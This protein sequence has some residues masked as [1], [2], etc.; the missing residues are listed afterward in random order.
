[1]YVEDTKRP[2]DGMPVMNS[3]FLHA[4][5]LIKLG[6]KSTASGFVGAQCA[7]IVAERARAADVGE[8]KGRDAVSTVYRCNVQADCV[9]GMMVQ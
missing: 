1:M 4:S 7:T 9:V 5:V 6:V 2:L 8:M 3:L